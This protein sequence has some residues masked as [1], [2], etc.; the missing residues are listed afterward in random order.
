MLCPA[1]HVLA[2]RAQGGNRVQVI[3]QT[4]VNCFPPNIPAFFYHGG[5]HMRNHNNGEV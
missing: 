3:P 2:G 5:N 1:L 4:C